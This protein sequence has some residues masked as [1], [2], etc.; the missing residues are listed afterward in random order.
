[1]GWVVFVALGWEHDQIPVH[2]FLAVVKSLIYASLCKLLVYK[3]LTVL[4]A[5][6]P[7]GYSSF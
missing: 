3:I 5:I 4:M 6:I 2:I 1:M 7:C